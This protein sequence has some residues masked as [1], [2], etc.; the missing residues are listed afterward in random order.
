MK[1]RTKLS[2]LGIIP[3]LLMLQ[4]VAP[5]NT[6][7]AET[8]G[9]KV[10][11]GTD[12]Y[13]YNA[14]TGDAGKSGWGFVPRFWGSHHNDPTP[15]ATAAIVVGPTGYGGGTCWAWVG[16]DFVVQGSGT[17]YASIKMTGHIYG[18]MSASGGV[19]EAWIDL[20]VKDKTTGEEWSTSIYHKKVSGWASIPLDEDYSKGV[21][22][23]LKSGHEYLVSLK[24]KCT[25]KI[26][27]VGEAGADFGPEDGNGGYTNYSQIF[28]DF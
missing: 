25:A 6:A 1:S 18:A 3:M 7:L 5:I 11:L 23:N 13:F 12:K 27:F 2:I 19:A 9:D 24:V 8:G 15:E 14:D 20:I 4:F 17:D 16:K 21:T 22:V 28:I 10:T 26:W